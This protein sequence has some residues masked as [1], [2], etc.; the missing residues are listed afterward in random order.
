MVVQLFGQ[1]GFK[2]NGKPHGV[3]KSQNKKDLIE[4]TLRAYFGPSHSLCHED[5]S[6]ALSILFSLVSLHSPPEELVDPVISFIDLQNLAQMLQSSTRTLKI[7]LHEHGQLVLNS[8]F[9]MVS[10]SNIQYF[11]SAMVKQ[12][13]KDRGL[14]VVDDSDDGKNV[15][16]DHEQIFK[17][18]CS[19]RYLEKLNQ[20][21]F[22]VFQRKGQKKLHVNQ[23]LQIL[24]SSVASSLPYVETEQNF[25]HHPLSSSSSFQQLTFKYSRQRFVWPDEDTKL[26]YL[27]ECLAR[28]K[29]NVARSLQ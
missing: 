5:V 29:M 13:T 11:V 2:T 17:F 28:M 21:V 7:T 14:M 15:P 3:Y 20:T 24:F 12:G 23:L 9:D 4:R 18:I 10:F 22:E 27:W 26:G 6:S 25:R 8:R 16:I 1:F 19:Q